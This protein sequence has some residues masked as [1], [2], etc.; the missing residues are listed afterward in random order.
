MIA[1]AVTFAAG[2]KQFMTENL[3]NGFGDAR[4]DFFLECQNPQDAI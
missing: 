4:L 1:G 3:T 2:M